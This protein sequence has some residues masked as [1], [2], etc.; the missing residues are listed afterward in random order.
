M[1]KLIRFEFHKLIRMKSLYI[2]TAIFLALNIYTYY[3]MYDYGFGE[4]TGLCAAL[5]VICSTDFLML[6]G[7]FAALYT[8]DDYS[9]TTIR[10]ILAR[11]YTRT[12][13]YFSKL[14]VLIVAALMMTVV[15]TLVIGIY[16]GSC[17]EAGLDA[18]DGDTALLIA[19]LLCL[20]VAITALYYAV[21]TAIGKTGLSVAACLLL[22]T[23]VTL[24]I[25]VVILVFELE[26]MSALE[27]WITN[28][29]SNVSFGAEVTS[30]EFIS[31]G[32]YFAGSV[33]LGYLSV[34]RREF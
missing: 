2:I 25:G 15:S 31:A 9:G 34:F 32:C 12:Q 33:F 14:I 8:C 23:V 11:G 17:W 16:A 4:T 13:I 20:L 24:A 22:D 5:D 30:T 29:I 28:I 27:Y 3:L 18:F 21:C 1:R 26:D 6:F 10:N 19:A 7:I